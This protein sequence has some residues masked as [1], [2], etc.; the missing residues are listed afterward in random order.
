MNPVTVADTLER[1]LAL[2]N[3][4]PVLKHAPGS[5]GSRLGKGIRLKQTERRI[6]KNQ[7]EKSKRDGERVQLER[8][9]RFFK[10]SDPRQSWTRV[11]VLTYGEIISRR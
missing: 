10:V 4:N 5:Q 7:A 9:S 11:D 6:E 3:P 8:I 1:R 2:A